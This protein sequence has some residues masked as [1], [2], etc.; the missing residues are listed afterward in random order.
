MRLRLFNPDFSSLRQRLLR[1]VGS[2]RVLER[3]SHEATAPSGRQLHGHRLQLSLESMSS[4]TGAMNPLR[5]L[6]S[7]FFLLLSW[8]NFAGATPREVIGGPIEDEADVVAQARKAISLL[9][10]GEYGKAWDQ[11]A[12]P[13]QD[14]MP[15]LAFIADVKAMRG[16]VGDIKARSPQ[17]IGFTRDLQGAPGHYAGALFETNFANASAVEEKLTFVNQNGQWRLAGY[18]LKKRRWL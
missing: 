11:A 10:A 12:K 7:A 5:K 16:M 14:S 8:C 3:C 6:L 15:R 18:A 13:F 4:T 9:D 1:Q 2:L 17:G